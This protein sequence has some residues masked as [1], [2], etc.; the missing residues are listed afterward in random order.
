MT[1]L[2]FSIG[3]EIRNEEVYFIV[4]IAEKD[5][6]RILYLPI[7]QKLGEEAK[8]LASFLR[9][10][11]CKEVGIPLGSREE[12]TLSCNTIRIKAAHSIEA[13]QKLIFAK[14]LLWKGSSLFLNPLS[15]VEVELE[16]EMIGSEGLLVT[17]S[18]I[19]DGSLHPFSSVDF[20][21]H[22]KDLIWGICKRIVFVLKEDINTSWLRVVYPESKILEGKEK[23][24]FIHRYK[25]DPPEGFPKTLWK[26]EYL[27]SVQQS[28]T[29]YPYLLLKDGYGAFAD[30]KMEY[31]E[32]VVDFFD[33]KMFLGRNIVAEKEWEKD[34]LET[35]FRRKSL[36]NS[37]YYC[38]TDKI[39]KSLSFLLDIGWKIFDSK[40]RR[41]MKMTQK[42]LSLG[43]EGENLTIRGSFTYGEH[44]ANVA[45]VIGAFSRREKFLELSSSAVAWLEGDQDYE[46]IGDLIS[47]ERVGDSCRLPKKQFGVLEGIK[48]LF[49]C[50]PGSR[51]LLDRLQSVEK[52]LE[53]EDSLFQG[54][55]RP[56]QKEG[57]EWLHFLQKN[58][59]SGLLADE[60]GL[61]KTVQTLSFFSTYSSDKPILLIAPTSLIFNWR[62]EWEAFIPHKKLH[63]H[64]GPLR[65]K[66]ASLQGKEAILTSYAYLRID[67]ALF[68]S[69]SF[70]CI[71]LDEAQWIKN[72][73]SQLA[74]ACFSLRSNMR[75]CLTGTPIENRAEDLWSLFH[76]LEPA[77]L[78]EKEDYVS[79]LSSAALDDRYRQRIRKKVQ[80]FLLR[81]RKEDVLQD[82][83]D[84]IEQVIWVEMKEEQRAFY[85]EWLNKTRKGLLQKIT[86][87]GSSA[88][89]MEV[90]EAVLRLRQICC[91]PLLVD[92]ETVQESAKVERVILDLEEAIEQNRKVLVYSQFTRMLK[93]LE[94]KI[95]EKG[96]KYVY[97]DGETKDREQVVSDFQN[98]A[99]VSI[100]LISLKAGGVGLN[101]TAAD[102]VFLFDP[103]W[104]EAVERQAIDRAHRFG[105]KDTV[106]AR[107]YICAET[108]EEKMMKLKEHKMSLAKGLLDFDQ[109]DPESLLDQMVELLK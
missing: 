69:L 76:F 18:L 87:E 92:G 4:T 99:S 47:T 91:D 35:D 66:G 77:L 34:L 13:M 30:L 44:T 101:L 33:S 57:K 73:E 20:L 70:S 9:K 6:S 16:A 100:F 23:D 98:D 39:A 72:P 12:Q 32:K 104:N 89:R 60:M 81:R 7:L 48:D 36:E 28:L 24:L 85:E 25:E 40:G 71:L 94:K 95:R 54:E 75:L 67:Q 29:V 50:D 97:L 82:L 55:L 108:I 56:Y 106:V 1:D 105:R 80:P 14:K 74:K 8:E 10:Q 27:S 109:Q 38:P 41:L 88:H 42:E 45:D 107:R 21:F 2:I 83:P 5:T 103:W 49:L 64:Q 3:Q 63:V 17:G 78:G 90:L 19:I 68:S 51:S 53:V 46:G 79:M 11:R 37:Q 59:F 61:G 15:K 102:Y 96:W 31:E 22:S 52:T 93:I 26:G 62:K 84:K 43:L 86:L 58:G 65:E